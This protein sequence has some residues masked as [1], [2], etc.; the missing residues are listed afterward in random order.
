[1]SEFTDIS[2]LTVKLS[3]IVRSAPIVTLLATVNTF[4][5]KTLEFSDTSPATFNLFDI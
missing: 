3:S 4:A 5:I 1:M 2:P